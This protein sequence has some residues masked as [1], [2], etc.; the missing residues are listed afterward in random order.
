MVRKPA[1]RLRICAAADRHRSTPTRRRPL[2]TTRTSSETGL[3]C[4][5]GA[6]RRRRAVG[7]RPAPVRGHRS[8]D[9]CR[10]A[11][12]TRTAPSCCLVPA[13]R[14]RNSIQPS[15][16]ITMQTTFQWTR[17]RVLTLV[18][19]AALMAAL[20]GGAIAYSTSAP[21]SSAAGATAKHGSDDPAGDDRGS[22]KHGSDDP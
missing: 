6:R 2:A 21:A 5:A 14:S 17:V 9:L 10:L 19:L 3:R 13:G 4:V 7:D 16:E 12:P 20:V 8:Y 1:C 15:K 22:A 18:A 11:N